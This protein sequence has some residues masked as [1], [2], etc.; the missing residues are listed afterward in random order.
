[1]T[2]TNNSENLVCTFCEKPQDQVKKLIAGPSVYICDECVI[3]CR[4]IITKIS[5]KPALPK[6]DLP[7]PHDIKAYLDDYVIGQ[8]EAKKILSVAV[9][10]HYKRINQEG[11]SQKVEVQKSNILMLGPTGTGKTLLAQSLA[12]MLE[13]PFCVVDATSLTEAGYVGD[14]TE[15][16]LQN[17]LA[18]AD[19]NVEQAERGIIYIDEI[20]KI[21]RKGD[22]PGTSRD[23]SGE[24]VQQSLLKM[25][26]GTKIS[27]S[28]RG[29]KNKNKKSHSDEPTVQIDTSNILFICGGAFS[30]LEDLI[31]RRVG[32]KNIGFG[33]AANNNLKISENQNYFKFCTSA[34]LALFGL[35][36][37]FIGR[38]P[39]VASLN[40]VTEDDLI[41]ILEQP[42]NAL[43]KQ[44]KK[45]FHMEG[46]ELNFSDDALRAIAKKAIKRKSGARGLRSVIENAMLDIMYEV[47]FLDKIKS[48]TVTDKVFTETE[49]KPELAFSI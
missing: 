47:P 19:N 18:M 49:G 2:D 48:C 15:S 36:P 26:E 27:V 12:K 1:M 33:A 9:Y 45:L 31:Q 17:L 4:D 42:K 22:G 24:G 6:L 39:I 21:A 44:Y 16:I 28:P 10:N 7:V 35:I 46:V 3:Q 13:V 14:D 23:V 11:I 29:S 25:I 5:K 43:I 40:Q 41:T 34:D 37:E 20:D 30:G 32:K 8:Y 38:L